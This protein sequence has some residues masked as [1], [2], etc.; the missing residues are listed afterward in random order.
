MP[1]TTTVSHCY[2][3]ARGLQA[4]ETRYCGCSQMARTAPFSSD[5]RGTLLEPTI[6]KPDLAEGVY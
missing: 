5:L 1:A 4:S 2:L 3:N 6:R